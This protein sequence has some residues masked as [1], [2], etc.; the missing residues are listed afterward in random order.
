MFKSLSLFGV[1]ALLCSYTASAQQ[2]AVVSLSANS[3]VCNTE[4]EI[5]RLAQNEQLQEMAKALVE[6]KPTKFCFILPHAPSVTKLDH[7]AGYIKFDYKSQILY[8]FHKYVVATTAA[9]NNP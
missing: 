9:V 1:T 2:P 4:A 3:H 6:I 5:A 8:T 7:Q